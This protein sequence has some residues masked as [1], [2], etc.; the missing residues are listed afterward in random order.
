M[1]NE[2]NLKMPGRKH[3]RIV[4]ITIALVVSL[5][6]ACLPS[7]SY[8]QNSS[9]SESIASPSPTPKATIEGLRR[10]AA[11]AIEEIKAA[12]KLIGSQAEQIEKGKALY[13]LQKQIESGLRNLLSLNEKEKQELRNA[14]A[15][16]DTVIEALEAQIG[17]LKKNRCGMVC[18][19]KIA[20]AAAGAGIVI[21]KVF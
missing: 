8:A 3:A 13:A 19:L 4:L 11:E 18:K 16:K 21:G 12:R 5:L 15:A 17:I 6:S 2:K 20:A 1:T 9:R 10:A 7:M 14:I